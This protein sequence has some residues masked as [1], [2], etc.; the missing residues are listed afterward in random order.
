MKICNCIPTSTRT[1][2]RFVVSVLLP[3]P[4]T[5]NSTSQLV[6]TVCLSGCKRR[7]QLNA[8]KTELLWC[9]PHR[10]QDRLPNAALRVSSN[11]VQPVRCVR[12]FGIYRQRCFHAYPHHENRVELLFCSPTASK[13]SEVRQSAGGRVVINGYVTDTDATRLRQRNP[14]WCS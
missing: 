6:S 8:A 2:L 7:L 10:Q 3:R 1:T 14:V 11:S 5:S 9:A 13:H 12:D 4:Q